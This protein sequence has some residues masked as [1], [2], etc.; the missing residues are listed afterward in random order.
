MFSTC[1]R[2]SLYFAYK[3]EEALPDNIE[4]V[5]EGCIT[6]LDNAGYKQRL[7]YDNRNE[8]I[9]ALKAYCLLYGKMA[10]IHQFIEGNLY[11]RK[12]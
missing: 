6:L 2:F 9:R 3:M 1:D 7:L 12:H 11:Q 5:Y 8:A 4:M 10:A